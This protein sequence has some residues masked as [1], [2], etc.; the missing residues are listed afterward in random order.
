MAWKELAMRSRLL[1]SIA[2]AHLAAA[3]LAAQPVVTPN[4][5]AK[6]SKHTKAEKKAAKRSRTR[7]VPVAAKTSDESQAKE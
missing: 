5:T 7:G 4:P 1:L 3:A 2:S 6:R